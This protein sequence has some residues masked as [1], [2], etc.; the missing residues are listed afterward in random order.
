[1]GMVKEGLVSNTETRGFVHV[2]RRNF[3]ELDC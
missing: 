1:M 2:A 3:V